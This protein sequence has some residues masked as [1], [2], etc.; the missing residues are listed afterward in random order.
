MSMDHE[1]DH[2]SDTE[3]L[4]ALELLY[5]TTL[6][7]LR[8]SRKHMLRQYAVDS[9]ACLL[10]KIRS[11]ELD[12]HPAYEHYLGALIIDQ[13]RTHV[14]AQA[15]RQL[16][17]EAGDTLAETSV[18]LM[19]SDKIEEHYAHR[20]SEPIRVSQDALLLFFDSGLMVEVRYFSCDEYSIG[21]CWG[22][23]LCRIDTA[24]VHTGCATFPHHLHDDADLAADDPI[25]EPGTPCWINF[26]ALIDLL[27]LDP[28]LEN[29]RANT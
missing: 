4:E 1:P 20:L 24:P 26:S 13:A 27:L 10:E 17:G 16:H 18:H 9:E 2:A 28:L 6:Y 19:L 23:A 8:E 22:D 21:W 3:A 15:I 29:R 14:R 11:G 5:A 25:T 7:T 12:E